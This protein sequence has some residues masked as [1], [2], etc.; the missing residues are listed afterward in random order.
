MN[1]HNIYFHGEIRNKNVFMEKEEKCFQQ[2][3]LMFFLTS[4]QKHVVGTHY[5]VSWR[6]KKKC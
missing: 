4:P 3:V 5:M 1:T 6:N 2:K